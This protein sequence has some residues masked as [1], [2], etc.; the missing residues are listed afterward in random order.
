MSSQGTQDTA[1]TAGKAAGGWG[2]NV[3]DSGWAQ[4]TAGNTI[5]G[6]SFGSAGSG[7]HTTG[8]ALPPWLIALAVVGVVLVFAK[9]RSMK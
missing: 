9:K 4:A 2:V 3:N 8:G 1:D 5:G 7:R 6:I